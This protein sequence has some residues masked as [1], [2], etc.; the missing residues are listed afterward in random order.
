MDRRRRDFIRRALA[1]T[2]I[3]AFG[4]SSWV[5]A[6]EE[7]SRGTSTQTL[8]DGRPRL[9][10]G[11][12]LIQSMR[13]MG[14]EAGDPDPK[15]FRLKIHG[16][17]DHPLTIDF[18]QLLALPQNERTVDVHCVTGW[19]AFD[20][21]FAGVLIRDL[22][23]RAG[24][25]PAARFM[26]CE[27]PGGYST[28]LPI[29]AALADDSLIA[30]RHNGA[31]LAPR[32]GGPARAVIPQRYFWKS[33]KWITGLRFVEKD[34]PGYWERLGYHNNADPWREQREG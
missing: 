17:V 13:P 9:P 4:D 6:G 23:Q 1:G 32:H 33:A 15:L 19:T 3:S 25:R 10:P 29:D 18:E 28:N 8:P 30:H 14:G 26:I 2:V 22:A 11:Q 27:A 12:R 5:I 16:A 20:Q 21:T 7:E 34:E 31:P 24:L